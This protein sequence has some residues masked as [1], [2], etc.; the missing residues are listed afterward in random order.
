EI[1]IL[2]SAVRHPRQLVRDIESVL[3]AHVGIRVDRRV[4]SV[5]QLR[6]DETEPP[7]VILDA[8][9]LKL[10]GDEAV[11]QVE[12]SYGGSRYVG[13]ASGP[14][15]GTQRPRSAAEATVLALQET[16]AGGVRLFLE[17]VSVIPLGEEK[18]VV[19][20]VGVDD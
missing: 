12:L 19:V 20:T 14:A 18:A 16:V 10:R 3:A 15:L 7:R 13:S 2:A 11:V 8:V 4:I 17:D 6:T 1:H 5:A 9:E